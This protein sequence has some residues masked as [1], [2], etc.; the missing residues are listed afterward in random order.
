MTSGGAGD[1]PAATAPRTP[2]WREYAEAV[3]V[4]VLL[5]LFFRTFVFQL[6]EIPSPSMEP[7][8][9]PGD[10]LVVNKFVY[11]P[12]RGPWAALLPHRDLARGD[13][14]VFRFPPDPSRDFIKR[15]IGLAGETVTLARKRVSV[16]GVPLVE[17][18]AV[19]RD[20]DVVSDDPDAPASVRRRDHGRTEVPAG[21]AFAMGDN[22][23]DSH[24]SR[25]WGP[26]P[27]T[28]LRGRAVLVFWSRDP[29]GDA[30]FRGRGAG[31][32]RALDTALHFFKR[33][34]W[35][36]TFRLVR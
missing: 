16:D 4:A 26:V 30:A 18:Y 13:V 15:A 28:H 36:R 22:R 24:D 12:H 33:T 20:A 19:F 3:L 32:R 6:Y 21:A 27:I 2:A 31:L 34:R 9:L 29:T 25:F 11:G 5:S 35:E 14:F 10:H 23:D 17:P 8:L 1:L 7:N